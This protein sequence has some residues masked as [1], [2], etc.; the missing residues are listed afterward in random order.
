MHVSVILQLLY[1][2]KRG[3]SPSDLSTTNLYLFLFC[4][5]SANAQLILSITIAS[6]Q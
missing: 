4:L 6:P 3:L 5:L 2:L 1:R